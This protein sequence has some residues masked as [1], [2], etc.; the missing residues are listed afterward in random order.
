MYIL[1]KIEQ[2]KNKK[3]KPVKTV[4]FSID[5]TLYRKSKY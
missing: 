3:I 1:Y 5:M 2:K 4:H